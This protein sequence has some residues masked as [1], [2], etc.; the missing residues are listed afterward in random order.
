MVERHTQIDVTKAAGADFAADAV[1]VT[2]AEVLFGQVVSER[3][4]GCRLAWER[5]GDEEECKSGAVEQEWE[6]DGRWAGGR[7]MVVMLTGFDQRSGG[8]GSGRC[9]A[10]SRRQCN[11]DRLGRG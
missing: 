5:N 9:L 11:Q 1:L 8:Q 10:G 3:H 4:G 2:D 6:S 7:T